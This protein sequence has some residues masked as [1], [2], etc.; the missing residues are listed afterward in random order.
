MYRCHNFNSLSYALLKVTMDLLLQVSTKVQALHSAFKRRS[1][2]RQISHT[3]HKL[4]VGVLGFDRCLAEVGHL[5]SFSFSCVPCTQS[6]FP[7][8]NGF[9]L[10]RCY[11]RVCLREELSCCPV[12]CRVAAFY[13]L[14]LCMHP[15]A[16]LCVLT[17][18]SGSCL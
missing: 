13:V 14:Q 10:Q 9:L 2:E 15:T 11:F 4:A 12:C 3:A 17:D 8:F 7:L 18:C 1:D 5:L 16:N 6:R